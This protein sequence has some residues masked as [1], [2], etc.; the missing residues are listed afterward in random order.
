MDEPTGGMPAAKSKLRDCPRARP[1]HSMHQC[2]PNKAKYALKAKLKHKQQKETAPTPIHSVKPVS[3][4][5]KRTP[6]TKNPM[7]PDSKR[8]VD[9]FIRHHFKN[10]RGVRENC[11][12]STAS[13]PSNHRNNRKFPNILKSIS[14][15][16]IYDGRRRFRDR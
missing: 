10:K 3:Q 16:I 7:H 2:Q 9:V 5:L 1:P 12:Q 8:R 14:D 4:I 6:P 13:L 15:P 11:W